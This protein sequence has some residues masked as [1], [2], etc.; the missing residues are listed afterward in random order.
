MGKELMI[1]NLPRGLVFLKDEE[2]PLQGYI[3]DKN[4]RVDVYDDDGEVNRIPNTN[5]SLIQFDKKWKET[6][7]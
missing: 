7:K 2:E 3:E 6:K 5:I 1:E 4:R